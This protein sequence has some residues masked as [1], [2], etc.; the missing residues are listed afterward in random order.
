MN[1][2]DARTLI[3]WYIE[4]EFDEDE[5]EKIDIRNV[6]MKKI[7]A[8]KSNIND[9]DEI[10]FLIE[11]DVEDEEH[12]LCHIVTPQEY[13][14]DMIIK[15]SKRFFSKFQNS[16]SKIKDRNDDEAKGLKFFDAN[17]DSDGFLS[18]FGG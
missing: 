4:A 17:H 6:D 9:E 18:L 2:E 10:Y 15:N 11:A 8:I 1:S 3:E 7:D 12:V 13:S 16:V 5:M 14:Q